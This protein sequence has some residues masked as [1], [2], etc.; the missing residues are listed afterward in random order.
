MCNGIRGERGMTK[1]GA[2]GGG[3]VLA[4]TNAQA[5]FPFKFRDVVKFP[6]RQKDVLG[7][8]FLIQ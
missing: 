8:V 5:G 6:S 3:G 1:W 2:R 7:Q 4:V